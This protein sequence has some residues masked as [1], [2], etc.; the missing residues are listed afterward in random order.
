VAPAVLWT[1]AA[2]A[3]LD[4]SP[5]ADSSLNYRDSDKKTGIPIWY[6][7][8]IEKDSTKI[9]AS[10]ALRG[11]IIAIPINLL[12]SRYAEVQPFELA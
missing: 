3:S 10:N 11:T 7:L 5:V 4:G 1:V 12:V 8:I 9:N 6:P 2:R